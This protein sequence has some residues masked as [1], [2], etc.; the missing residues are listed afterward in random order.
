MKY[1]PFQD[2]FSL[3]Y[4]L[5]QKTLLCLNII[6]SQHKGAEALWICAA[7][8]AGTVISHRWR[9]VKICSVS[10]AECCR[11]NCLQTLHRILWMSVL[12]PTFTSFR[13]SCLYSK[14]QLC[15]SFPITVKEWAKHLSCLTCYISCWHISLKH[16]LVCM[17]ILNN[18]FK[19]YLQMSRLYLNC[20]IAVTPWRQVSDNKIH[21]LITI[22]HSSSI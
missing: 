1:K 14:L 16:S 21:P 17:L 20:L 11:N 10:C 12:P 8:P 2:S 4:P 19:S 15:F 18:L 9:K 6:L 13:R 22:S 5:K 3:W 7:F